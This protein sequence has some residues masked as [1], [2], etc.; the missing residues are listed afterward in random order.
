MLELV[1]P[2]RLYKVSLFYKEPEA[3]VRLAIVIQLV[4]GKGRPR[5]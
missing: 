3:W 1:E 5:I 4:S 2:K